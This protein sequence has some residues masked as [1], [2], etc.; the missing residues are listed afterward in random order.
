MN[1]YQELFNYLSDNFG[2]TPLQTDMQEI[3]S[4]V[5]KSLLIPELKKQNANAENLAKVSSF[6]VIALEETYQKTVATLT[7]NVN[8][9]REEVKGK[10]IKINLLEGQVKHLE[11][12]RKQLEDAQKSKKTNKKY[13][14]LVDFMDYH[15]L[16]PLYK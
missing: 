6:G 3:E 7:E 13:K 12:K 9:L 8:K 10:N 15:D 16:W 11:A 14:R 4:I 2:I 5:K 1:N